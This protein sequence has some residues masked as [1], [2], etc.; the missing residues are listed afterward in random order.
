MVLRR[1]RIDGSPILDLRHTQFLLI[2][3]VLLWCLVSPAILEAQQVPPV[4]EIVSPANGTV[5]TPGAPLTV[6][7]TVSEGIDFLA[8]ALIGEGMGSYYPT[9]GTALNFSFTFNVPNIFV[10]PKQ[11]TAVGVDEHGHLIFSTSVTV[12]IEPTAALI[13]LDV[14]PTLVAFEYAGEQLP[15]TVSGTYEDGTTFDL[16][17]SSLVQ[18]SSTDSTVATVDPSGLVTAVGQGQIGTTTIRISGQSRTVSVPVSVPKNI[19]GDLTADGVVNQDDMNALLDAIG[20]NSPP[21]GSFDARD[22]NHDDVIDRFD[23]Q[24][25]VV[26]CTGSP[27]A[28]PGGATDTVPPTTTATSSPA[29]NGEGWNN[30]NVTVTLAAIDNQGGSDV[31]EIH[32][33]SGTNSEAIVPGNSAT[34]SLTSE[35]VFGISFYAVDNAGNV[36][37]AHSLTVKIDK[38]PPVILGLPVASCTLWPPNHKL[39]PVAK[40]VS[41]DVL[42]GI[43]P[44]SLKVTGNSS[45]PDHGLGDGDIAP[46]LVFNA[47]TVQLRAERSGTGT[48]RSYSVQATVEDLAGNTTTATAACVV[49]HDQRKQ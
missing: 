32:Y 21:I 26:L 7:V 27:C 36:D 40:I 20:V 15:L 31:R 43:V 49:P 25:L 5:V 2:A 48:G 14:T 8:V 13:D 42:S 45:E 30:T 12:D 23:L 28:V 34:I 47:G 17:H 38:T 37:G 4:L 19:L 9:G 22:L 10:G 33:S 24:A 18:Y 41:S 11:L 46:D 39:V 35:G 29:P 6:L 16:T 44:G 1:W 3:V